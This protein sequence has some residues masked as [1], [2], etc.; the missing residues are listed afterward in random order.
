MNFLIKAYFWLSIDSPGTH[1]MALRIQTKPTCFGLFFIYFFLLTSHVGFWSIQNFPSDSPKIWT[2]GFK[3]GGKVCV[4]TQSGWYSITSYCRDTCFFFLLLCLNVVWLTV[5]VLYDVFDGQTDIL[6]LMWHGVCV[7]H[8]YHTRHIFIQNIGTSHC[9]KLFLRMGVLLRNHLS[10][11]FPKYLT[12][13]IKK[14]GKFFT[15]DNLL[16]GIILFRVMC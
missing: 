3:A 15:L 2:L 8:V 10:R 5:S 4:W 1:C 9:T 16:L 7:A 12:K 14:V 6:H 11:V 13:T